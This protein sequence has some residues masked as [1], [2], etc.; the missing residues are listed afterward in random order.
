MAALLLLVLA[1]A[2]A[3][4]HAELVETAPE[5][6]STI[7]EAPLE[8]TATFDEDL[9]VESSDISLRNAAGE[10][11]ARGR[12]DPTEPRVLRVSPPPDLADGEYE[13]RWVAA[14][15]DGHIER[16]S[17]TFRLVPPTLPNNPSPSPSPTPAP[18]SDPSA[19]PT[20]S[21]SPSATQSPAPS[22]SPS[23]RPPASD[24]SAAVAP[25]VAGVLLLG[26]LGLWLTRRRP[27]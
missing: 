22:P 6:G 2:I 24:A 13:V 23:T 10:R 25:I 18:S 27:G 15:A 14:S 7:T 19:T 5:A 17:F 3:L 1:P 26:L 20:P 12:V 8:I 9:V 11:I 16:G 4:A 21:P